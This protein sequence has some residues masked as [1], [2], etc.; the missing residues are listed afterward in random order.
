MYLDHHHRSDPEIEK[1][2]PRVPGLNPIPTPVPPPKQ[3][4]REVMYMYMYM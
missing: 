2:G 3:M 4:I 1:I